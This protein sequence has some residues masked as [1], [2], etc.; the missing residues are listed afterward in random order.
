MYRCD[1]VLITT[2]SYAP[3]LCSPID[4]FGV[5]EGLYYFNQVKVAKDRLRDPSP[6]SHLPMLGTAIS[7]GHESPFIRKDQTAEI[8]LG[9]EDT[10]ATVTLQDLRRDGTNRAVPVELIRFAARLPLEAQQPIDGF[11]ATIGQDGA[12]LIEGIHGAE[13]VPLP[14]VTA[15]H[16]ID[17]AAICLVS[18]GGK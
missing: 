1:I 14:G 5:S 2:T 9:V 13:R 12:A 6:R 3:I 4:D 8:T 7:V 15:A 16:A 10:L 17:F 18:V 11:L